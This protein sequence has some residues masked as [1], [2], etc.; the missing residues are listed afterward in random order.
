LSKLV[1]IDHTASSPATSSSFAA[2][3]SSAFTVVAPATSTVTATKS[4]ATV[5]AVVTNNHPSFVPVTIMKDAEK[6]PFSH[7][8]PDYYNNRRNCSRRTGHNKNFLNLL[9]YRQ[10]FET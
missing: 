5:A 3:A 10:V 1:S 8:V 4:S 7:R 2:S 6:G 9:L